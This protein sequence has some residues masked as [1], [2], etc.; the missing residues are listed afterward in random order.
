MS[1]EIND[2][3]KEGNTKKG[4]IKVLNGKQKGKIIEVLYYP[5]EYSVDKSN[6]FSEIA[7]PGLEAP[8]LQYVRG[9]AG[10]ISLELFY[11]TYELGTDVREHTDKLT[12]LLNIDTELHAPP[13]LL[14]VWGKPS[15]EP[16]Q[17]VLE[18]VNKKI[19]HVSVQWN[20]CKSQT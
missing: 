19:H 14:F 2:N 3:A 6:T 4:L 7:I 12:H 10:S 16:F 8:Y 15:K 13:V 11:D 5:N 9:N 18:K 17:C 20:T 1:S